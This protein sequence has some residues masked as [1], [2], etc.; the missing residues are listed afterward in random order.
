MV[1][2]RQLLLGTAVATSL[3]A[4]GAYVLWK[5]RHNAA[6]SDTTTAVSSA[7][8][9]SKRAGSRKRK[10]SRRSRKS[11]SGSTHQDSASLT[12]LA[13]NA[14]E[15]PPRS[16]ERHSLNGSQTSN[17]NVPIDAEPLSRIT[18]VTPMPGPIPE[19]HTN[20][21]ENPSSLPPPNV[22]DTSTSVP[23]QIQSRITRTTPKPARSEASLARSTSGS[24]LTGP[25]SN[26]DTAKSPATSGVDS[27]VAG[28]TP[29]RQS[30]GGSSSSYHTPNTSSQSVSNEA[31]KT[32]PASPSD[33][34]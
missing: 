2:S 10:K 3:A 4:I 22:L 27:D 14:V 23:S 25:T 21:H 18:A 5:S 28:I 19:E 7:S 33:T 32:P 30:L 12:S 11:T 24:S 1:S 15:S 16:D 13:A 26:V 8:K 29:K 9:K 6:S 17:A 20:V 31:N 34:A